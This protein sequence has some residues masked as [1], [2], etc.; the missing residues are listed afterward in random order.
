PE[1]TERYT[2]SLHDAL[3]LSHTDKHTH[4]HT[5]TH[6]PDCPN[7]DEDSEEYTVGK[8]VIV[9]SDNKPFVD[10]ITNLHADNI[11]VNCMV[12]H[13]KRNVFKWPEKPDCIFYRRDQI[14][15]VIAEPEPHQ[16]TAHQEQLGVQCLAQ[17]RFDRE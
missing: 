7:T 2:L 11:E 13:G 15:S 5:H 9:N 17:G 4:T 14:I 10:Q 8:C 6:Y 12:Q 3:P 1:R 16:R